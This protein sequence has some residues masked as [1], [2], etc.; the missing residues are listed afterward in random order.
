M[1]EETIETSATDS[2]II[3]IQ[4]PTKI[5]YIM[6]QTETGAQIARVT[7]GVF[8]NSDIVTAVD[9]QIGRR[10]SADFHVVIASAQ[11]M[12]MNIAG[13]TGD[14]DHFLSSCMKMSSLKMPTKF[15]IAPPIAPRHR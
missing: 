8:T 5:S 14:F 13:K 10:F 4:L 12:T 6:K 11:L 15:G 2:F 3:P 1:K 9:A 7:R